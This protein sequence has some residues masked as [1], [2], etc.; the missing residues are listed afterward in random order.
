MRTLASLPN[1]NLPLF[2]CTVGYA[3]V[4]DQGHAQAHYTLQ[5]IF[6]FGIPPPEVHI[7]LSRLDLT[8][9][10]LGVLRQTVNHGDLDA[11]ATI[12]ERAAFQEWTRERFL[13]KDD[14]L[15]AF[16]ERGEFPQGGQ[17]RVE[18]EIRL[19][20]EDWVR[21]ALVPSILGIAYWVARSLVGWVF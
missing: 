7:H 17:E 8:S 14:L 20:R 2:D 12:K 11:Q 3:G 1:C 13:L 10:P 4:P 6:G 9:A 15:S 5:S 21:L 18:L 16:Y 19:R